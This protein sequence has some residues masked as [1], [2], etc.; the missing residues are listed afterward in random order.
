MGT[1]WDVG[2]THTLNSHQTADSVMIED[3]I[4]WWFLKP[5]C[6]MDG[7]WTDKSRLASWVLVCKTELEP[8]EG[9]F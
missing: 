6:V 4:I 7:E 1:R 8:K 9:M 2:R 3:H 5:A